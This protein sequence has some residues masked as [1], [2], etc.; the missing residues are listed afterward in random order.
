MN[1][2]NIFGKVCIKTI[3]INDIFGTDNSKFN[4]RGSSANWKSMNYGSTPD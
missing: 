3:D 2:Y 4:D 1:P